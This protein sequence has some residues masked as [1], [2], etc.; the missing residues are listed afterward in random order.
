MIQGEIGDKELQKFSGNLDKGIG[1]EMTFVWIVTNHQ[2]WDELLK[3]CPQ[4][5]WMQSYPYARAVYTRDFKST[6]FAKIQKCGV[7]L[8]IVAVQ[9]IRLG[10][11]HFVEIHRGP[12]W[13]DTNV[14]LETLLEFASLLQKT[15]Q[16]KFLC[17]FRWFPEWPI[18]DQAL[19]SLQ[20]IGMKLRP[21]T[22][23]T[24]EID[25]TQ[26]VSQIRHGFHSKWRNCLRKAEVQNL[27]IQVDSSARG[28]KSFLKAYD[29]YKREK[30][31]LGPSAEF[32]QE[33][34]LSAQQLKLSFLVT[35]YVGEQQ[36]AGIMIMIHGK[37]ASYRLGWNSDLGKKTNA[38]YVLLWA[39]IEHLH[40]LKVNKFDLGGILTKDAPEL[41]HFK[42][43]MGGKCLQLLG[44]F[45]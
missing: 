44:L 19:A 12:L 9:E 15:F 5:N 37:S 23:E 13:Y 31:F 1:T 11:I 2:L 6:R 17:R 40:G 24:V 28:L 39:A 29:L 27:S 20:K 10:P 43:G 14:T 26:S 21:Q 45:S 25:L 16:K 42:K 18:S 41:T 22:F 7:D 35:A 36:I 32:M 30:K 4:A 8:G 38:H 33:E 3:S 34:Y